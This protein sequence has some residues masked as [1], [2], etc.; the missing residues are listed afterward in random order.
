[1]LELVIFK[2]EEYDEIND[3][4]IEPKEYVIKLEHS[5][6]SIQKWEARWCKPFLTKKEKTVEEWV[7]YVRCMTITQNVD[8][9]AYNYLTIDHFKRINMYMNLPMTATTLPKDKCS[10][11]REI[12]TAELVYYWMIALNIPSEYR[13]WH[14]NQLLTLIN[15][16]N[17]KNTPPKKMS[18]SELL[19][20]HREVNKA[21]RKPH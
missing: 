15:V 3:R 13:K 17:I 11:N 6:V 10:P 1:M 5:L 14:F 18:K 21:R 4:F 7:D 16:C 12:V 20:H 2:P 19:A 8:P 9:E